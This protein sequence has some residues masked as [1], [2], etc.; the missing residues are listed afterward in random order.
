MAHHTQGGLLYHGAKLLK[1]KG[2]FVG[3]PLKEQTNQS[4]EEDVPVL[5]VGT[6]SI[7]SEK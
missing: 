2:G 4:R 3:L 1:E 6:Q 5:N 7:W